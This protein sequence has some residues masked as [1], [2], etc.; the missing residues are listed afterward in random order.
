[1]DGWMEGG[2]V[3]GKGG[4]GERESKEKRR[5]KKVSVCE[6]RNSWGGGQLELI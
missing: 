5:D 1:M 3:V 2:W 4:G 6:E